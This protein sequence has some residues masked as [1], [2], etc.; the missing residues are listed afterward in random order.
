MDAQ[1]WPDVHRGACPRSPA[2]FADLAAKPGQSQPWKSRS[3]GRFSEVTPVS[4]WS[5]IPGEKESPHAAN[6]RHRAD[7]PDA[8]SADPGHGPVGHPSGAIARRSERGLRR[9]RRHRW[10]SPALAGVPRPREPDGAARGGLPATM[11]TSGTRSRS[12]PM[13]EQWRSSPA[14]PRSRASAPMI[15]LGPR[16][17]LT[18]PAAATP[19]RC[20]A[21]R[22]TPWPTST[23]SLTA[24]AFRDPMC[25]SAIPLAASSSASTRPP[26]RM[27]SP[28]WCSSMPA[29]KSS[30]SGSRQP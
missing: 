26:T 21:P 24:L 12:S 13:P 9:P 8:C 16:L 28:G 6:R 2:E 29:M 11:P 27:R 1:R 18:T 30:T 15:V 5:Q 10:W 19:C 3:P 14:S 23:P 20:R 17:M 22:Q 7:G 4:E 25:W